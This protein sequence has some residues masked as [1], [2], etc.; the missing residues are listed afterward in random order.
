MALLLILKT[1]NVKNPEIDPPDEGLVV[2]VPDGDVSIAAAGEAHLG[3]GADGQR[4]AG[5]SGGGQLGFDARCLG[6]KIPNGQSASLP[7][8]NKS[9]AIR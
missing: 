9:A 3:V 7:S 1:Y 5:R 8:D 4:V 2:E 6:G